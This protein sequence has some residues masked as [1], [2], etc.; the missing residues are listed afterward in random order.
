MDL[1]KVLIVEDWPDNQEMIKQKLE[2]A[3]CG[4][5]VVLQALD[6]ITAKIL[7]RDNPDIKAIIMDYLMPMR[8]DDPSRMDNTADL[9]REFRKRFGFTGPIIA[10][11][12]E[13]DNRKIQLKAGCDHEA[14]K[15]QASKKV[16]EILNLR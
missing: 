14:E 13:E 7:F 15:R 9:I 8:S 16:I 10:T 4:N 3:T 2:E 1:P 6:I 5:I 12:G 11:S